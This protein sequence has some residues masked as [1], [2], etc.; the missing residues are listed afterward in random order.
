MKWFVAPE[1][2]RLDL[3]DGQWMDIKKQLNTGETQEMYRQMRGVDGAVDSS[4]IRLAKV[5]AYLVDWSLPDL[6]GQKAEPSEASLKNMH[7]LAFGDLF[8]KVLAHEKSIEAEFEDAK[9]SQAG[10]TPSSATFAS[11]A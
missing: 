6:S 7:P 8:E 4:K 9:K 2:V 1:T 3:G 11:A 10:E 5:S